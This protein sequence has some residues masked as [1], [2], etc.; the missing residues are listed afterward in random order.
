MK[1]DRT[2][3]QVV[4]YKFPLKELGAC[5]PKIQS[6]QSL[7]LKKKNYFFVLFQKEMGGVLLAYK[8]GIKLNGSLFSKILMRNLE[9]R[10]N[11]IILLPSKR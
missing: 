9:Q 6:L 10:F 5:S 11:M 2:L 1:Q 8:R 7:N 3:N 4:L